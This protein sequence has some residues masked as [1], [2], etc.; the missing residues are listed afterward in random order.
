MSHVLCDQ[1]APIESVNQIMQILHGKKL[2]W[3]QTVDCRKM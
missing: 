1:N 3:R 2:N